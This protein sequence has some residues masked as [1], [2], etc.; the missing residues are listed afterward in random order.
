MRA[1]PSGYS[2]TSPLAEKSD[3][4]VGAGALR[5][6]FHDGFDIARVGGFIE[7]DVDRAVV[8]IAEVDA[9][10]F[11][12]LANFFEGTGGRLQAQRVEEYFVALG[13]ADFGQFALQQFGES[14]DALGDR[15][16]TFR[17][18]IDGVEAGDIGEQGLRGADIRGR[19]FAADVLFAGLQSHAIRGVAVDVD[20][21]ADDASGDLP[22]EFF[23]GRE[24]CGVRASVAERHSEALRISE[25]DVGAHF[26]GRRQQGQAKQIGPDGDQH[27]RR[28]SLAR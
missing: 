7:G 16:Q 5:E 1:K 13:D 21:D 25:D 27:A 17:P 3:T 26:S 11:G 23:A 4:R 18:V 10:L 19:L 6:R 12:G 20:R 8:A 15:G 28:V 14:M 22:H 2:V 9:R 24:E